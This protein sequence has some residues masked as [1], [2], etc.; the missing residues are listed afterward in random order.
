[1]EGNHCGLVA[2]DQSFW[3]LVQMGTTMQ[4]DDDYLRELM[5]EMEAS[6]DWLHVSALAIH[7]SQE[8]LRKHY[9]MRLLADAGMLEESG[10][11]GGVF[12]IT[13]TGHDFLAM[14]RKN[15][16]WEATKETARQLGG[17]SIQMLYRIAEGLVRQKLV[18]MG[19][20]IA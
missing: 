20:P 12:R 14:I 4:R 2:W 6:P 13:N 1:M 9:H 11:S 3:L 15:E 10:R 19:F 7:S 16:N 5:L 18:D 17:A 8:Q